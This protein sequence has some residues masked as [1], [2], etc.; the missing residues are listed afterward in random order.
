MF[1]I[2]V[3]AIGYQVLSLMHLH[4]ADYNISKAFACNTS[5]FITVTNTERVNPYL[6]NM[7]LL[8]F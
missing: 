3:Q 8:N 4:V 5:I 7:S 1:H 6:G 2:N